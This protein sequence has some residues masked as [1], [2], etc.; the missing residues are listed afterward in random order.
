MK[1]L[2]NHYVALIAAALY[3]APIHTPHQP[4]PTVTIRD[5]APLQNPVIH[6]LPRGA[7]LT[8]PTQPQAPY[9]AQPPT[10]GSNRSELKAW[11]TRA[12]TLFANYGISSLDDRR[13]IA[14][15][16][17]TSSPRITKRVAKDKDKDLEFTSLV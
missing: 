14:Y 11:A 12:A 9:V 8:Q 3:I 6:Q 15:D 1:Y 4:T 2:P 13:P 10:E 16:I 17:L 5:A 7:T